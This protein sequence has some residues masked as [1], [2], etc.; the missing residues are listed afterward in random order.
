[1]KGVFA[2][3]CCCGILLTGCAPVAREPDDLALVRV[4]GVD[5]S[6][7]VT[8]CAVCEEIGGEIPRGR[9][10]G[11]DVA[12]ALRELPW[13]GAGAELTLTGVSFLVVGPDADLGALLLEVLK[14]EDLGAAVRL[15]LAPDGAVELLDAADDPAADLE[16]VALRGT[17]APTAARASAL[18]EADGS[19]ELPVLREKGGRL[20]EEGADT[21]R[22]EG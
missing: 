11:T 19:V 14:E 5:G 21:W 2:A 3:L 7:P 22:A 10:D 8:L 12:A 17:T 4:L 6:E 13:S 16:L 18:L 15:W 20:R 1:M 9:A